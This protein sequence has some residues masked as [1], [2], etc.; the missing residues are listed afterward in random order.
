MRTVPSRP[1]TKAQ[2]AD[3]RPGPSDDND[4]DGDNDDDGDHSRT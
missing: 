3:G 2:P 4:G 1:S